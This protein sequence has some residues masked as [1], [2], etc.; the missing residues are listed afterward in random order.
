MFNPN[1]KS[2][3]QVLVIFAVGLLA[4]IGFAALAIDVAYWYHTRHQLQ[5]AADAAALAGAA[6]LTKDETDK[7]QTDARAEALIFAANN[8]A[9]KRSVVLAPGFPG[10]NVLSSTNDIT[11]GNWNG[12]SYTPNAEPVNA[13][14]VRPRRTTD[15]PP[16]GGGAITTFFG[17]IFGIDSVNISNV[18]AI[19]LRR[20]GTVAPLAVNEYWCGDNPA[21]CD[22]EGFEPYPNSF[23]RFNNISTV[24]L[25]GP[26]KAMSKNWCSPSGSSTNTWCSTHPNQ[27]VPLAIAGANAIS[28]NQ[29]SSYKGFPALDYRVNSY[30]RVPSE[31]W[32]KMPNTTNQI[33][34]NQ[35]DTS[36]GDWAPYLNSYPYVPPVTVTERF[37][38][39]YDTNNPI[40]PYPAPPPAGN[41]TS[42]APFATLAYNT[43]VAV[44]QTVSKMI[45]N[46]NYRNGRYEPGKDIVVLVYDGLVQ[47]QAQLTR[48]TVVGYA[49]M[50]I[51]GYGNR[52]S[53]AIA[54]TPPYDLNAN[55]AYAY[56]LE[57]LKDCA[58]ENACKQILK[59]WAPINVLLVQ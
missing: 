23:F 2:R 31:K 54:D 30:L 21:D 29:P 17:R 5:G 43:G 15:S 55:S 7:T 58:T 6:K 57:P 56:A 46:G 41:V 27:G 12:T 36:I 1:N 8:I 4:F 47:G 42:S 9:A 35:V 40:N 32:Y 13:V 53:D 19:A 25:P 38:A 51:I 44:G 14:Q 16:A 26:N 34:D 49:K 52:L 10:N 3:G 24:G 45:D 39:N 33:N 22:D 28:N 48:V 37:I 18:Q 50:R 11:V 20:I 59:E